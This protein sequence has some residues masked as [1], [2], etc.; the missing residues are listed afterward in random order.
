MII[1]IGSDHR[2][3]TLKEGIFEYLKGAGYEVIDCG[4]KEYNEQDDYVDFASEVA[5]HI[6]IDPNQRGI[7]LC[8]SG[9][10]V[11]VVANKFDRVRCSLCFTPDHAIAARHDDDTNMLAI[12]AD[13]IVGDMAKKIVS[14]WLQ[15]PFGGG[16]NYVRRIQKIS[17]I[18]FQNKK[19]Q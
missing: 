19:L 14:V 6:S 11:D 2:G 1:Y 18:E 8:G 17:N 13:F 15:T 16:D 5:R 4:N 3:F 9:V 12:P 10:G 7:V